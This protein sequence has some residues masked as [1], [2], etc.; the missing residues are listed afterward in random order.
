MTYVGKRG[1]EVKKQGKGCVLEKLKKRSAARARSGFTLVEL[2][3]VLALIGILIAF[4]A[5]GMLGYTM[6]STYK[7][8]NDNAK[9]IFSAAQSA[10]TY[11]K[12]SGKLDSL[13]RKTENLSNHNPAFVPK[14]AFADTEAG[15]SSRSLDD[16]V[17]YLKMSNKDYDAIKSA[18]EAGNFDLTD[19]GIDE[20][21]KLLFD[22]L[23]DYVTDVSI[24]NASICVEFDATDGV[25]SGVLYSDKDQE[26]SYGDGDDTINIMKR[27][28]SYRRRVG[29]GYYSTELSERAPEKVED[30][31]I[32]GAAMVN[33][34]S[35]D[36]QWFLEK[37]YQYLKSAQNYVIELYEADPDASGAVSDDDKLVEIVLDKDDILSVTREEG[38][39]PF[40]K[41]KSVTL[42]AQDGSGKSRVLTETGAVES[43]EGEE[44]SGVSFH[45]YLAQ[46]AS[47]K[48][49]G[50]GIALSLDVMDSGAVEAMEETD[51]GSRLTK[52]LSTYSAR[53]LGYDEG[54]VH[55]GLTM[56]GTRKVCAK[57]SVASGSDSGQTTGNSENLFF[58]TKKADE[59]AGAADAATFEIANARHLYNV[60]LRE[61]AADDGDAEPAAATY[62]LTQSFA[63]GGPDG[64]LS[65]T[66][67]EEDSEMS[68]AEDESAELSTTSGARTT[69]K[70]YV[71]Q[72]AYHYTLAPEGELTRYP[73]FPAIAVLNKNSTL[74]GKELEAAGEDEAEKSDE[75][76]AAA[77]EDAEDGAAEASKWTSVD[78]LTLEPR[79]KD[80]GTET[81]TGLV[82]ENKGTIREL[83]LCNASVYGIGVR[84]GGL[85]CGANVGAFCGLN[86]GTLESLE[87]V[88]GCVTGGEN[89]GGIFGSFG[90]GATV[91]V[92]ALENGA[93][94]S[95]C[96]NVGGIVGR[97]ENGMTLSDAVNTGIVYGLNAEEVLPEHPELAEA[98]PAP[99]Y[100]GGIAGY[101]NSG[102]K[103]S[104]C[105]SNPAPQSAD[106]SAAALLTAEEARQRLY[107]NY[108]GGI[109][110]YLTGGAI[111]EN[112]ATGTAGDSSYILGENFV[113]GIV[114]MNAGGSLTP[115][116]TGTNGATVIG[117]RFVGGIA[118]VNGSSVNV[119]DSDFGRASH[120]AISGGSELISGWTNNGI[121]IGAGAEDSM[122]APAYI[123]GV[124]GLNAGQIIDCGSN[125]PNPEESVQSSLYAGLGGASADFTGGIAGCN[126]G[127][128]T[129]TSAAPVS[130]TVKGRNF[131][132]G[133]AGYNDGTTG[134]VGEINGYTE[135]S[136][137]VEGNNF[138]GGVTGLNTSV[139]LLQGTL[140]PN[141]AGVKGNSYVGGYA[142]ANIIT[143]TA[144]ISLSG[145][146]AAVEAAGAFAG[147]LFGYNRIVTAD[148]LGNL[149]EAAGADA[150]AGGGDVSRMLEAAWTG[151]SQS[152]G[153]SGPD[154][155][156]LT[157][158]ILAIDNEDD[159]AGS[160]TIQSGS[161]GGSVQA[162][163]FAGGLLGYNAART[164]LTISGYTG[165][166]S[167]TATSAVTDVGS[168]PSKYGSG[169]SYSFSGG[170][171]GYVTENTTLQ[172]C[173]AGGTVTASG[174]TYLGGLAEVNEGRIFDCS[175]SGVGGDTP[176]AYVGGIV[177]LNGFA[178]NP[179]E[180]SGSTCSAVS[181]SDVVGG[182]AAENYGTI[183][184]GGAA[185]TTVTGAGRTGGVAGTNRGKIFVSSVSDDM[186]VRV[187]QAA[188]ANKAYVGGIAGENYGT[189]TADA[190]MSSYAQISLGMTGS[191]DAMGGV[192]GWNEGT[193]DHVTYMGSIGSGEGITSKNASAY[194]GIAGINVGVIDSCK[195]GTDGN[196]VNIDVSGNSYVGGVAGRNSGSALIRNILP[197][198]DGNPDN[199]I[200]A[201]HINT[202]GAS[203][204]GGI[205]GVNE[206]K[207]TVKEAYSGRSWT[208]RAEGTTTGPTGGIIGLHTSSQGLYG[209]MN[210]AGTVGVSGDGSEGGI[211]TE[212]DGSSG[213]S[214]TG[215]VSEGEAA[216][217][218][219]GRVEQGSTNPGAAV[220][221]QGCI[222]YGPVSAAG[223]AGGILGEWKSEA[224][225]SIRG[226]ENG[227]SSPE[228][229]EAT[230]DQGDT[231][232]R[233]TSAR[234]SSA[235]G[236]VGSFI[237]IKEKVTILSCKNFGVV[238]NSLGAGIA[239]LA[240]DQA[241]QADAT[242]K[243]VV[244]I[245]DCANAGRLTDG[246]AGIAVY[247]GR[248]SGGITLRLNRC[249]NYG[250]PEND[251]TE[252]Q[253]AGLVADVA[254][255]T[256]DVSG[257]KLSKEQVV[258]ENSIGVANVMYPTVPMKECTDEEYAGVFETVSELY[259]SREVYYYSQ[260]QS[261]ELAVPSLN[262][263]AGAGYAVS[264]ATG[265][266]KTPA[267]E[268]GEEKA[269]LKVVYHPASGEAL[270]FDPNADAY[271]QDCR[272]NYNRLEVTLAEACLRLEK[273]DTVDVEKTP[274]VEKV[275]VENNGGFLEIKWKNEDAS[276]ATDPSGE[277]GAE[278]KP[279]AVYKTVLELRLYDSRA[280]AKKPDADDVEPVYQA[281]LYGEVTSHTVR[282]P[283]TWNH[284]WAKVSVMNY[285][286]SGPQEKEAKT[287]IKQILPTLAEP[288]AEIRLAADESGTPGYVLW[289]DNEN[290]KYD[291]ANLLQFEAS[292]RELKEEEEGAR[293]SGPVLRR[294]GLMSMQQD[295]TG[296][297]VYPLKEMQDADAETGFL[298]T[299]DNFDVN[300][301]FSEIQ[302]IPA[303]MAP[304][305]DGET[306]EGESAQPSVEA[307]VDPSAKKS[308][309]AR[310]PSSQKLTNGFVDPEKSKIEKEGY[311]VRYTIAG[312]PATYRTELLLDIEEGDCLLKDIVIASD[313]KQISEAS[314][315]FFVQSVIPPELA[316]GTVSAR[317][318][319]IEMFGGTDGMAK[320]GY[321]IKEGLTLEELKEY[322]YLVPDTAAVQTSAANGSPAETL[323]SQLEEIGGSQAAAM[324][325]LLQGQTQENGGSQGETAQ[326]ETGDNPEPQKILTALSPADGYSI[327]KYA[328][329][330]YRVYYSVLLQKTSPYAG[331]VM[332]Q[333]F[334]EAAKNET[335]PTNAGGL[336]S[337][338]QVA[339]I[340]GGGSSD[341]EKETE[342][343]T[344]EETQEETEEETAPQNLQT[345][346]P[347]TNPQS[348][349]ENTTLLP[350]ETYFLNPSY[351]TPPLSEL[352]NMEEGDIVATSEEYYLQEG[353]M[354]MVR[355]IENA[356]SYRMRA[357]FYDSRPSTGEP[358]ASLLL[359]E[360]PMYDGETEFE[361]NDPD[362]GEYIF[363]GLPLSYAGKW[364]CVQFCSISEDGQRRSE[365]S[366]YKWIQLPRV[367][368]KA[369]ELVSDA[370]TED[371]TV[372]KYAPG[373]GSE[374]TETES[375]ALQHQAYLWTQTVPEAGGELAAGESAKGYQIELYRMQD[376]Q[377]ESLT[378][379]DYKNPTATVN[380]MRGSK[381]GE[382]YLERR[383]TAEE[384]EEWP[385]KYPDTPVPKDTDVCRIAADQI[386]VDT[387]RDNRLKAELI[388]NKDLSIYEITLDKAALGYESCKVDYDQAIGNDGR[389][390]SGVYPRIQIREYLEAGKVSSIEYRLILPDIRGVEEESGIFLHSYTGVYSTHSVIVGQLLQSVF[391][392][393]TTEEPVFVAERTQATYLVKEDTLY[394]GDGKEEISSDI[395]T[396]KPGKKFDEPFD[397]RKERPQN[398]PSAYTGLQLLP[399]IYKAQLVRYDG[400]S[401]A[402]AAIQEALQTDDPTTMNID[403]E[404]SFS[405]DGDG[406]MVV[407][408]DDTMPG[409]TAPG[410]GDQNVLPDDE[411]I[412][413]DGE[414]LVEPQTQVSTEPQIQTVVE[415]A[416]DWTEAQPSTASAETAMNLETPAGEDG[417]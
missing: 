96:K 99:Q 289:L 196:S 363:R 197:Y 404:M 207:A 53:R 152:A 322:G 123:G 407:D 62:Q 18:V 280:D 320:L 150:G 218:I 10:I 397:A 74:T 68:G 159:T 177:G 337:G 345:E 324:A 230:P 405:F 392:E 162:G 94:V 185:G 82:Q 412:L 414:V 126:K 282:V 386:T 22:L 95:G 332:I 107:G 323:A 31:K 86:N 235:A 25:V 287:C 23:S 12:A 288:K 101:V 14:E 153:G 251:S 311:E 65:F 168:F 26:F 212:G 340:S 51:A 179:A 120:T 213:S 30:L 47:D 313:Q 92:A 77:D 416:Q 131:V 319:P 105:V 84:D 228:Q 292:S 304:S 13:R 132:G 188:V 306:E 7:R 279:G 204:T 180:I 411:A 222:N 253:F 108:V 36:V 8:N 215:V 271:K 161:I 116:E 205:A 190:S 277:E 229:K 315:G 283:L 385:D 325:E 364:L 371:H 170:I 339:P 417:Q 398:D 72:H 55:Y 113:G 217:G 83:G 24:Y 169:R 70:Y 29:L 57:V 81:A 2:I 290:N 73:A 285:S 187:S 403:N 249:R 298:V 76:E 380:L 373:T 328:D 40:V 158:Q 237:N 395:R 166:A 294:I 198:E 390:L 225:G 316:E 382:Y 182:T 78:Y 336:D 15:E 79:K 234:K 61:Q 384:I 17:S 333:R 64:F 199:H 5:G 296:G 275:S 299:S 137:Y 203:A 267:G 357:A 184:V 1:T 358:D 300:L 48:D 174:A 122:E 44:E 379:D 232:A 250:R 245:K 356:G 133:I 139:M 378:E 334:E 160:M 209:L 264:Y 206:E 60:G 376:A 350:P 347:S 9:T 112:C 111:V 293:T 284:K 393:D 402:A 349:T 406:N 20:E 194:G 181:G 119:A 157:S 278:K 409:D 301:N 252:S 329:N 11:Y 193:I 58:A 346:Q 145:G 202:L 104:G 353:L 141:A 167:V 226:C 360:I 138:V 247:D 256:F 45:A 135:E 246:G 401:P 32:K 326:S 227:V 341:G 175:V 118:G 310:V 270:V 241:Q 52:L 156:I 365:W 276:T 103:I 102:A 255:G 274:S 214:Q 388:N 221:M 59:E 377:D 374:T 124:V 330:T 27:D 121:V 257:E 369:P 387:A 344:E 172:S 216:G 35:L 261:D 248:K 43:A 343:E 331:S 143:G 91:A 272:G 208:I 219:V 210:Y 129:T 231:Q 33:A 109:A 286:Y 19:T 368:L 389:R 260:E 335:M 164:N 266:Y 71:N 67:S 117:R 87:T 201:V 127:S 281:T 128:L 142:G 383:Y 305:E 66:G 400:D 34:E 396:L 394:Q 191:A 110:G 163:V 4:S 200:S 381:S 262:R 88:G 220:T 42:Y 238:N 302:V 106:G 318:Y 307:V 359:T 410:S 56:D 263:R 98:L 178:A 80:D 312:A 295:A 233:I 309:E 372:E 367:K 85:V 317:V 100:I 240:G 243:A 144:T 211:V 361:M 130:G 269:Y 399:R 351:D 90:D 265:A 63:W 89:V 273:N 189:I 314:G 75:D 173:Q 41:A 97:L 21:T 93:E 147:G 242:A 140:S 136:V 254:D 258:I 297:Y 114:G 186:S 348:D 50:S 151:D 148:R 28:E 176:R 154:L 146:T 354:I 195:L 3:V 327:E 291:S 415:P 408:I 6:Y 125:M 355:S 155:S 244:E 366:G 236:I 49:Y 134:A 342:S 171:L 39:H 321:L 413:E 37:K 46:D 370:V 308:L 54:G 239:A 375:V 192:A 224:G 268:S 391:E 362:V 115:G 38:N 149:F 16:T 303:H 183:Y 259:G 223:A 352:M 69:T 338:S 165:G